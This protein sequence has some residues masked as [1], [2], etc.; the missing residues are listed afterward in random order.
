MKEGF[1][2]GSIRSQKGLSKRMKKKSSH[3]EEL[4]IKVKRYESAEYGL[5]E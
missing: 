4:R 1:F 2:I 5:K 3:Q